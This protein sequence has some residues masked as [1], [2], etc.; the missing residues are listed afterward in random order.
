VS[1]G[2]V[3]QHINGSNF[4]KFEPVVL[5]NLGPTFVFEESIELATVNVV[6]VLPEKFT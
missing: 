3:S 1:Y 6:K 5:R 4:F 2:Q